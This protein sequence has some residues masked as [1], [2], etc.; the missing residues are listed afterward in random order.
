MHTLP[1]LLLLLAA[2]P[3]SLEASASPAAA[4]AHE[5]ALEL[6]TP[7]APQVVLTTW[8]EALARLRAR[9]VE[10]LLALSQLE[11]AGAQAR[12]ALSPLLPNVSATA[13]A[14]ERLAGQ[15]SL[16][17]DGG[18]SIPVGGDDEG[19]RPTSPLLSLRASATQSVIDVPAW[20]RLSA[21]RSRERAAEA[22]AQDTWRRVLREFARSLVAIVSAERAVEINRA[23]LALAQAR[24][25]LTLESERLGVGRKLDTLRTARDLEVTHAELLSSVESLRRAREG[26]GLA[27]GANTEVGLASGFR[28]EGLRDSLATLC[29]PLWGTPRS[30]LVAAQQEV[31]AAE[32]SVGGA[33]TEFVPALGLQSTVTAITVDPGFARVNSWNIV[34]LL[35]LPLWDGGARGATVRAERANLSLAEQRLESVR[36]ALELELSQARRGVAL[37]EALRR[38]AERS[39]EAAS[40]TEVLTREAFREGVGT[41]L[42]LVQSAVELREAERTLVLRE[43]ELVQ[44]RV[45]ALMA[46]AAC[47]L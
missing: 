19:P 7:P 43:L 42:E 47:A 16:T 37:A 31:Q 3:P 25:Q 18:G 33:R 27:L 35:E 39:R 36:R 38:A 45:E 1:V 22:S 8:E 15:G 20:Y 40:Q 2:A 21:A 6:M 32:S 13:S 17:V 11:L 9:S 10:V 30:D 44:A 34:A 24:H 5:P 26:L 14:Q 41:S 12:L 28:L 4:D 29:H 46:E 23:A